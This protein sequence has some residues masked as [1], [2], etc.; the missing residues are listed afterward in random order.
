MNKERCTEAFEIIQK[1]I[2]NVGENL[3]HI[4]EAG[5]DFSVVDLRIPIELYSEKFDNLINELQNTDF[6]PIVPYDPDE[7]LAEKKEENSE[8]L[9]EEHLFQRINDIAPKKQ[10]KDGKIYVCDR[11]DYSEG[12][13][14][15]IKV[16]TVI[17]DYLVNLTDVER[18]ADKKDSKIAVI[19]EEI[20][21]GELKKLFDDLG[22]TSELS[23][24]EHKI[25]V[26]YDIEKEAVIGIEDI[27]ENS[28]KYNT[29][30]LNTAIQKIV[31]FYSMYKQNTT[32]RNNDAEIEQ[33]DARE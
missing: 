19:T 5:E 7:G 6:F 30:T 13:K 25:E 17:R 22:V 10:I 2:A 31:S 26:N 24:G 32:S 12:N 28:S 16:N 1:H 15:D 20:T 9:E 23:L 14:S 33:S 3:I 29:N 21:L 11:S 27:R 4:K 18:T 8:P